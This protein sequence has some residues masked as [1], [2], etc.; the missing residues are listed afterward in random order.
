MADTSTKRREVSVLVR[1]RSGG[2]R[3]HSEQRSFAS[4]LPVPT[5]KCA[6]TA[7][8]MR[9]RG[10]ARTLRHRTCC[11][12]HFI[13]GRGPCSKRQRYPSGV[14]LW[15]QG[16]PLWRPASSASRLELR[17]RRFPSRSA[18][19]RPLSSNFASTWHPIFIEWVAGPNASVPAASHTRYQGLMR[20]SVIVDFEPASMRL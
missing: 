5:F 10:P 1:I 3:V 12:I 15:P 14:A 9:Q 8:Q 11:R 20:A 19:R 18:F 2:G 6:A 17:Q 4:G 7:R 16:S 13:P